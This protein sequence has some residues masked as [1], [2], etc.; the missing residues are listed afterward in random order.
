MNTKNKYDMNYLQTFCKENNVELLEN[1]IRVNRETKIKGKCISSNC[2]ETFCKTFRTVVLY[3]AYCSECCKN[4]GKEKAKKT[5]LEKYGCEYYLQTTEKQVKSKKTNLEK[6]GVENS[7]QCEDVRNKAKQTC[8]EKY[9]CENAMQNEEIKDKIKKTNLEK[10]GFVSSL[11]CEDVKNK[12]KQTMI[13]RYGVESAF[14]CKEI[15]ER[16]ENTMMERYGVKYT[17]QNKELFGKIKDK[18]LEKYGSENPFQSDEF[19]QKSKQTCLEKYG[20]EYAMQNS[21]IMDKNSKN[22]YKFKDYTFPSGNIIKVQGYEHFALDELQQDGVLEEE[23][24]TGCKNVPEIWYE[25][26]SGKQHRHYVDIFIPSKNR[27]I[28]IKS[29]WTVE[30]KKDCIFLKKEAGK[31]LG[32]NY[33]I[34]VYNGKGEKVECY[35]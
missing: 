11:Q 22:A 27:C 13:E 9:G 24:I 16:M 25:D 8:L 19:K 1:Y 12:V 3:N 21:E 2:N 18:F 15:K 26:T 4:I 31:A 7:M 28:E 5:F 17:S 34:W 10:Y 14:Q 32:Y 35:K 29:T 20:V 23:I 6:Y 33:E 30:K